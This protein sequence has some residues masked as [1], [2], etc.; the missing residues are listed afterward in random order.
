MTISK[1]VGKDNIPTWFLD[2]NE[3]GKDKKEH[4]F[5]LMQMISGFIHKVYKLGDEEK[6][7]LLKGGTSFKVKEAVKL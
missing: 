7:I 4:N 1:R 6:V 5:F 2:N 3:Q